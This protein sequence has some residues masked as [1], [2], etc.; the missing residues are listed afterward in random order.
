MYE[1]W[2]ACRPRSMHDRKYTVA[3]SVNYFAAYRLV[4]RRIDPPRPIPALEGSNITPV[5]EVLED[6]STADGVAWTPIFAATWKLVTSSLQYQDLR[7]VGRFERPP[8]SCISNAE[9]ALGHNSSKRRSASLLWG[10]YAPNSFGIVSW[11]CE[12]PATVPTT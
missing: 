6:V 11:S 9:A 1:R 3:E 7:D 4:I 10:K 12:P 8:C 5:L 2:V